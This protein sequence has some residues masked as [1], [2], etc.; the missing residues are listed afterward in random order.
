MPYRQAYE[1]KKLPLLDRWLFRFGAYASL[2]LGLSAVVL[3]WGGTVYFSQGAR[4]QAEQSAY[5]NASN[6]SRAFEEQIVRSIHAADQTLL[7]VRGEYAQNPAAFDMSLW[8]RNSEFL[9]GLNFQVVIIGKDGHMVASNIPGSMSGVDL[10]DREHF[11]VHKN[12][13]TDELFISKPVF[14]RV[15]NKWSIQLTR[16]VTMDDGSFGGVAVVSIS[17]EYLSQFYKSIDVGA[18]GTVTLVGTDDGIVRARGAADGNFIGQSMGASPLLSALGWSNSGVFQ[19]KSVLDGVERLYAYRKVRDYPLAVTVGLAKDEVFGVYEEA[20]R[21]RIL[22]SIALTFWLAGI[23]WLMWRYERALTGARD[24]AEAGTRARSEFLAMMSH[25]IR[26]PMNGVVGM[27]EILADSGLN[28]EQL[29]YTRTLRQS[30]E[31]LLQL[32]N[33]V[34]D[35][36]KLDAGRVEIERIGF[37]VNEMVEGSVGLLKNSAD[38]KGLALAIEIAPDVPRRLVGDPARLRQ[39][40]FNLVGNGLKFTQQGGVTVTIAV[41]PEKMLPGHIRLAFAVADTGIGIPADGIPLLFREFS[42]LDSSVARRFGGTG[43]GLAICRRL[44]TL[45]GGI[46]KVESKVGAGTTF[47]FFVDC[48]IETGVAA[49]Q[50]EPQPAACL[51]RAATAACQ[52]LLVE[53]NKTNQAVATTLLSRLGYKADIVNNGAEAV[54][55]CTEKA[56]D[57]V[58]MDVMMPVMDGLT[59]TRAIRALAPPHNAPVIV[60]LTANASKSDRDIC[61]NAGMDEFL[62]KPVT[63]AALAAALDKFARGWRPAALPLQSAPALVPSLEPEA[64]EPQLLNEQTYDELRDAIGDDGM[65]LVLETFLSDT[66]ERIATMRRAARD[67]ANGAVKTEVHAIKSSAAQIG[68]MPLSQLASALEGECLGLAW[69]DLDA[70]I[71]QLAAAFAAIEQIGRGKLETHSHN[72]DMT[73]GAV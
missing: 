19:E 24:A 3:I 12:R 22:V 10:S 23:T 59:A 39:V 40:L 8:S 30:A 73:T 29:G 33:D 54:A 21:K 41:D 48:E 71:G 28:D 70:R 31:Y 45:M 66:P 64:R 14:G 1:R 37:D 49:P 4:E 50:P 47:R 58:F 60:A 62:T 69:P 42:Q 32:I 65:T 36:S 17:P 44:V 68:F 72:V 25:E 9:S 46:I 27:S 61:L 15:S 18:R 63:R 43:L 56:Y 7:Y 51:P 52:V 6:L 13:L 55:R 26:T 16:K 20:S 11:R 35:F 57:L 53:D 67:R 34:L 5:Q 38:E 2:L